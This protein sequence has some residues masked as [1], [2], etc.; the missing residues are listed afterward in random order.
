M[1][2]ACPEWKSKI[3]IVRR[4]LYVVPQGSSGYVRK[5]C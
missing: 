5:T 3:S 2:K 4:D 1:S